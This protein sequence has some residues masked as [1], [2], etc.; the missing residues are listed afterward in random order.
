MSEFVE[1]SNSETE[2]SLGT[3]P[4][5]KLLDGEETNV[6]VLKRWELYHLLYSNFHNQ[7]DDIVNNIETDLK[8][9]VMSVLLNL[10]NRQDSNQS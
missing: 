9:E 2:E 1:K 7:V 4:F 5:V 10:P 3:V 8:D 6:A